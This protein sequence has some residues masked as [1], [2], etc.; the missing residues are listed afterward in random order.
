MSSNLLDRLR[1]RVGF[2]LSLWYVLLFL[3]SSAVLFSL[4]YYLLAAAIQNRERLQLE[5]QL[6]EAARLYENGGAGPCANGC[7]TSRRNCRK[8]FLSDW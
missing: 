7:K 8:C 4:T 5:A 2:Q 3:T 6:T 1:R